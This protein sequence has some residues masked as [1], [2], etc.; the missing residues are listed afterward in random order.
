M[1]VDRVVGGVSGSTI[2]VGFSTQNSLPSRII[3]KITKSSVSHAWLLLRGSFMGLDMVLEAS[4]S[5]FHLTPYETFRSRNIIVETVEPVAPLDDGVRLAASWLGSRY[6]FTG[7]LG[8]VIVQIGRWLRRKWRNPFDASRAMF[9][10]EAI[11]YVLRA[12]KYPGAEGL[13]P[14]GTSPE[15]LLDF[16]TEKQGP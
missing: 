15:D 11:V 1:V 14:S 4:S 12:A 3:R 2:L 6:D 10:S 13:D 8:S 7:L 16:L 9:C 5:G